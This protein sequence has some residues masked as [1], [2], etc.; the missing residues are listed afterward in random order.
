M[1][2]KKRNATAE[3]NALELVQLKEVAA[4]LESAAAAE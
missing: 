4:H 3:S 2:L 1:K